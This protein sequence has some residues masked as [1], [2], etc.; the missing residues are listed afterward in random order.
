[1]DF[2]RAT[3]QLLKTSAHG[4]IGIR[5]FEKHFPEIAR[6]A[7]IDAGANWLNCWGQSRNW[8]E[9]EGKTI[10]DRKILST[11][12][13]LAKFPIRVEGTYHAGLLHTYGYLLSQLKTRYG[14]KRERWTSG[15]LERGLGLPPGTFA[16]TPPNGTLLR[17]V[18]QFLSRLTF[19]KSD[20][21]DAFGGGPI[22]VPFAKF[23]FSKLKIVRME[24][25]ATKIT[26][27][28]IKLLTDFVEFKKPLA[29]MSALLIYS[30]ELNNQQKLFTCFPINQEVKFELLQQVDTDIPIVARFNAA[31]S[32]SPRS[33]SKRRTQR[34]ELEH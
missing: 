5:S 32:I 15:I 19:P 20:Y 34:L 1:M 14:Y 27:E 7:R 21:Q 12:G 13:R 30:M 9:F 3:R 28:P 11:I 22:P 10:V 23:D 2:N 29:N 18:T 17:N 4:R 25:L 6:Q 8:D 16:P 31:V 33:I 24:E 26:S